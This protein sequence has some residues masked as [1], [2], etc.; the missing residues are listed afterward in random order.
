MKASL[1]VT[2]EGPPDSGKV[3]LALGIADLCRRYGIDFDL[4]GVDGMSPKVWQTRLN[5]V[6]KNSTVTISI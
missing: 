6:A 3:Y 1:T 2:I 4:K 5:Q